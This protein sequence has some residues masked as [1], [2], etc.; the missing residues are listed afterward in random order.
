ME[1][2]WKRLILWR[3]CEKLPPFLR[4]LPWMDFLT[5]DIKCLVLSLS[6]K[7]KV[8]IL[9]WSSL[10]SCKELSHRSQ[11]PHDMKY[12]CYPKWFYKL[13][14]EFFSR[15]LDCLVVKPECHITSPYSMIGLTKL[16]YTVRSSSWS[17][18]NFLADLSMNNLWLAFLIML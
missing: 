17:K 7:P 15:S 8:N 11:E 4:S 12:N 2:C 6:T 16:L 3:S 10:L 9:Q 14:F 18:P 5:G 1:L 13:S